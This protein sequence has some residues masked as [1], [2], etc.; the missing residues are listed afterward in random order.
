MT[1]LREYTVEITDPERRRVYV[2]LELGTT[3]RAAI[4][5]ALISR[6]ELRRVG[7]DTANVRV[8]RT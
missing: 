1:R 7:M 5:A 3:P 4:R 8:R 2:S 6:P